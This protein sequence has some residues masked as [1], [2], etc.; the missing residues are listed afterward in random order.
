MPRPGFEDWLNRRYPDTPTARSRFSNVRR[1][2]SAYGSLEDHFKRDRCAS[3]MADLTY[4]GT[5]KARN[6]PN[7]S[8]IHIVGDV[9]NGLVTLRNALS[10]Y[11]EYLSGA[12]PSDT[13]RRRFDPR[14]PFHVER[15]SSAPPAAPVMHVEAA[16]VDPGVILNM[17]TAHGARKTVPPHRSDHQKPDLSHASLRDILALNAATLDAL[18]ARGVLRSSNLVGDYGE[19]LFAKAFGWELMPP[20]VKS[21]DACDADGLRYQIKARRDAG[22]GGALQLGIM[23]NLGDDG[24]DHLAAALLAADYSVQLAIIAPRDVVAEQAAFT[25]HQRG[26]ILTIGRSF[27]RDTRVRVVTDA[28]RAVEG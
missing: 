20:S 19:W 10:L 23:R 5:D 11:V 1:I 16:Q 22:R 6:A 2:E 21:H 14:L 17:T 3:V 7:R 8:R 18:A 25:S 26:H 24:F 12:R 28:L 13:A 15:G 9:Y 4:T 27:L